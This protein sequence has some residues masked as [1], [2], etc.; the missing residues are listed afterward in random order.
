MK[1]FRTL[2]KIAAVVIGLVA[3]F[4]A[5]AMLVY[6]PEYIY[7][8]IVW[9]DSDAFDWRKFPSHSLKAAPTAYHFDTAPDSRV[10]ELFAQLAVVDDWNNFLEANDTQAFIVIKDGIVVYENYF[11]KTQRDSI[12][13]SFSVAKSFTSA[14]I[15][16]AIDE[17]YIKSVDDPITAY[18][19][20]LAERDPRFNEITI[21]NLLMMASGLEYKAF[22]PLLMNSDDILT[23][24]FPDQRKIALENTH[25]IDPPGL[26][27]RYNKYHPQL[28]GMILER[29]T[30]IPVATYLQTRIWDKLG[31]E[32]DGS[33][34]TDSKTSDFEK[35]ETGV[36]ARAI[37][38]AKLGVLFLNDGNWQG[39]QVISKAWVEESTQ[40]SIPQ[41]YPDYYSDW[42]TLLPGEGTYQYMWYSLIRNKD[43][44]DFAA[45]G[46]KGQF[47]YVSPQKNLVIVRNGI[48]YGIPSE[49][50][51][52]LFYDFAS[53][54]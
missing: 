1:I 31:M 18:L 19:P 38:F 17:G 5:I 2:G 40:P 23:T 43:T 4:L 47:I 49:K 15:G 32:F 20:E 14:L 10:D 12:V 8:A 54:Y 29:T 21:R 28:L 30:G 13:T 52:N 11:N 27:Y 42:Y 48:K 16:I 51:F 50:W 36:N 7:R 33:W 3:F 41:N 46:D 53:Q 6:P 26:Y 45:E 37:D 25:I 44:Y 34:S 22:R 35:M 9:Q 39:T 24:Y